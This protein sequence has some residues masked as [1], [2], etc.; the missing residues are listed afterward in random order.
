MTEATEALAEQFLS[1]SRQ[2]RRQTMSRIRPLGLNPHQSRAL[3]VIGDE[4]PLRPSALAEQLGITAR[5]ASE[6]TSAL[7]AGGWIQRSPDTEDGRAYRVSLTP[8]GAALLHTVRTIRGEVT[9]QIFGVLDAEG[10]QHLQAALNQLTNERTREQ[11]P[12][13]NRDVNTL[14]ITPESS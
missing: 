7:H 3:R 2:V 5:S 1:I 4:G 6:A 14:L 9:Q 8:S 11:H 10:R 13:P 12:L